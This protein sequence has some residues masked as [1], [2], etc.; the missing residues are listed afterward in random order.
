MSNPSEV[1]LGDA[2]PRPQGIL[3]NPSQ[4]HTTQQQHQQQ[5]QETIVSGL[6]NEKQDLEEDEEDD[7]NSEQGTYED[8]VAGRWG[9]GPSNVNVLGAE[10]TFKKLERQLTKRSS[11]YRIATGEKGP[12]DGFGG[13]FDLTAYLQDVMPRAEEAGIKRRNLGVVWENLEVKGEGLG[14]QYLTTFAD[15]FI[16]LSNLINPYFWAK[17]AFS[18]APSRP[19]TITRTIIHPMNGYCRDGE[20]VLVLGRPGAGC[21]T[22]L[23]VLAN[24][25]KN[26]KDVSGNVTYGPFTADEIAKHHRGEVVYNQ[27]DDFHYPTLTVRQT[28]EAAIKTKTPGM[29][30][31]EHRSE[32]VSEFLEVLTKMYGLTKQIETVVGNAFIRGVSGGERK[33]LS[34]AEQMA[35][36]SSVNMWDGSTRGLDASSALDYIRSVRVQ[37]NLLKKASI[38]TIYQASENIY[39]LFDRTLLL[40]EGRCIYFGPANEAKQYF[41]D[42]GFHCP[43]RQTT[44][45][46]L[47]AITDPN[48]RKARS[49]FLGRLPSTPKEFEDAFKSSSFY[50]TV[51]KNR[52]EYQAQVQEL[53]PASEFKDATMQTKQKHVSPKSPYTINFVG[54]VKALTVRQ[55]QLTRGD[56][57]SVISRYASNVI[58]ALIVGSVFFLLPVDGSGTFT[59][60][61]VLFFSL[62]FNALISQAELPMAMTG[63]SILYK[64]KNFAMYRPSAFAIAQICVDI[65][66]IIM[67]ILLFSVVLYFM[68]GLKRDISFLIFMLILF[69]C[70]MCMTAFFRMWASVSA[71]FDAAARNSGLILLAL[72]LYSGY[73][74]PYQSMHPWFIW[75]FWI[76]PLAYGF[77]ALI[78]NEMRGLEFD[79][80]KGFMV[81]SGPTYTDVRYQ[82]CT[83]FGSEPGQTFVDGSKYLYAGFRYKTSEMWINIVAVI[84]FWLFFVLV[85]CYALENIEF[86]KGGF[87]TNVFKKGAVIFDPNNKDDEENNIDKNNVSMTTVNSLPAPGSALEKSKDSSNIEIKDMATGS[88][89]AWEDLNYVVPYKA[90]KSG[91]KQL[92]TN[93]AG[94]V[95]PGTM[96]AL[97]GS[98]GAGKTTL[99]DVLA[100]RKNTGTVT[101]V[102][103]V[104]G[105]PLRVDFQRTTGYCEQLDVHVPECTVREALQFSAYL[106]QPAS[107][108]EAEKDA[109]VE[110]I[111]R[112]LEMENIADAVIGTTESGLG[113][114]VEERKRLTIG[115]ELVAKPKLLFLDEPTSGLDAQA[116]YN[117]MRFMRKLTDQGQAILCTIHQPSSQLFAF[118]DNLLLLA[119]GGKTVFFGDLG[120]DS[121]NLI[122]YFESN[123]AP[124]CAKDAN[125]AEYILDV[126]NAPN[127]EQNWPEIWDASPERR[128]LLDAIKETRRLGSGSQVRGEELEYATDFSL[129]FKYVFRR[130]ARTYWRLPQYNFGRVFMMVVFALLNGFS[131]YKL[132]TTKIDLQSRVFVIFQVMV[133]AALLVTM[134]QPRFQ[135]ERQW[136]YREL[137][138]KYYG[139][140]P[141][142]FTAILIEIPYVILSGT[143]FFLCFYWTTGMLTDPSIT[144]YTWVLL[145]V[146]CLFAITLGQAIAALTPSAQVAALLNP[147]IFSTLN[148]F[149]GVMIPK[150]AMPKF[151]SSWMYWL[152]PYH[153]IIEGLVTA[154]LYNVDVN[155]APDEF[156]IFNVPPGQTCGDYAAEFLKTASGYI[157]N[158]NATENCEYCQYSKGQDFYAGLSMDFEN[159]WRN[160]GIMCI[161]LAFNIIVVLAAVRYLKWNKR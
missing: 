82:V 117:I 62:L 38:V 58:K 10:K 134:V 155:C 111:I 112:I 97:M 92:L 122:Q 27:E 81:P 90:D 118:F 3:R 29:R 45:D 34:I 65:P 146:F 72:I 130:M 51:E 133:M 114:S 124:K 160:I 64:H 120:V 76:N 89:F 136:F 83:L 157:N 75:F 16:G 74:I 145:C 101:G 33:R 71:T 126:V 22:L 48:E 86:G 137:A 7:D 144:F 25:R 115:V 148:L 42:M 19:R 102:I 78:A 17:K 31:Q 139:W 13:D 147:F 94:L 119:K 47:T 37:T 8:A 9:E 23:R 131:F 30:L 61:G 24:Q 70:A 43:P 2:S 129:Q 110:E 143:V 1:T 84:L 79:C 63:R 121:S 12:D 123:G 127:T 154:Q 35:V 128:E 151:W 103:E 140:K 40:Y 18:K 150:I 11:L 60:G 44:P 95:K 141:F 73:M 88:V 158:M 106:R 52:I 46:F 159:R 91:Q 87:S 54:Q 85:T 105:E 41:I 4:H 15:P 5:Q 32:F 26:Y 135:L 96:T 99:L 116:S 98:S 156:S 109:Y 50:T 14:A 49:G 39:D 113:I 153:Y 132:G 53:N 77:K 21:S 56:M 93:I 100:Q 57:T 138:G 59:R 28:L 152:D 55:I 149:C 69:C 104:D 125:P 108:S 142:A 20:M 6:E 66:L 68:A 161:Y 36:R 107:V 67:Q 80:T